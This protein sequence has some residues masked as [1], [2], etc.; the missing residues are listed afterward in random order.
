MVWTGLLSKTNPDGLRRALKL[1]G[2]QRFRVVRRP[3]VRR[4]TRPGYATPKETGLRP[5]KI[6]DIIENPLPKKRTLDMRDTQEFL[7]L[8]HRIREGLRAG[9]SYD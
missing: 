7:A 9:H 2:W 5:G 8:S 3:S 6:I 1:M 4:T